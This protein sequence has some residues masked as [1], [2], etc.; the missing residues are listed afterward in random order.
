MS[1]NNVESMPIAGLD[2]PQKLGDGGQLSTV[3]EVPRS[4][5][6][7]EQDLQDFAMANGM[8][9]SIHAHP[10][11]GSLQGSQSSSV[12][13]ISNEK[14]RERSPRSIQYRASTIKS[15]GRRL[16]TKDEPL[17]THNG[18]FRASMSDPSKPPSPKKRKKS[19][20]GTV[21]RR[22]FGKRSV[23]NRISLPAPTE[24]HYNVQWLTC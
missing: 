23:K 2:N 18:H 19:G 13:P 10:A 24:N 12:G 20:L 15:Q 5:H 14:L 21:I 22:I 3:I 4:R 8:S 11:D 9:Q 6:G 7:I 17:P 1:A 16:S